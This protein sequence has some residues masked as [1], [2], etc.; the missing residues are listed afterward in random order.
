[1]GNITVGLV[2]EAVLVVEGG[3][4]LDFL[5]FCVVV[6]FVLECAD[7]LLVGGFDLLLFFLVSEKGDFY[8][9]SQHL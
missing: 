9:R 8:R 5:A 7:V 4:H 2:V 1:M 3:F 6:D